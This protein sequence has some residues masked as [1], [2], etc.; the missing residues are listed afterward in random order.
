MTKTVSAPAGATASFVFT[1]LT[2]GEGWTVSARAVN[3]ANQAW[4]TA[5]QL[6]GPRDPLTLTTRPV[7]GPYALASGLST[8]GV[9]LRIDPVAVTATGSY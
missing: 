2:P 8:W 9:G 5:T 6:D 3:A 1:G 7:P 4:A